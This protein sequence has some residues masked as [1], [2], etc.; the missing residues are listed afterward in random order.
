MLLPLARA[1][2]EDRRPAHTRA[3]RDLL[4]LAWFAVAPFPNN[5]GPLQAAAVLPALSWNNC[6]DPYDC[7]AAFQ[8]GKRIPENAFTIEFAGAF[9]CEDRLGRHATRPDP[10]AHKKKPGGV[11]SPPGKSS[12]LK[13][14][15]SGALGFARANQPARAFDSGERDAKKSDRRSP[16]RDRSRGSPR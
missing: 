14:P 12:F 1:D 7:W 5:K 6:Q 9:I 10:E 16:I 3:F 2:P 8:Y 11:L 13:L 15:Y 4:H